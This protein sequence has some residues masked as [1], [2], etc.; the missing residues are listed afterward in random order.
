VFV[1]FG[2]FAVEHVVNSEEQG[3]LSRAHL[4]S[5]RKVRSWAFSVRA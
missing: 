4:A 2:D 1:G 3:F 5:L